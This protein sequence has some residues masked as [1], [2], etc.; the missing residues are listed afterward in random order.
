M[1]STREL[2][3]SFID[4]INDRYSRHPSYVG[5]FYWAV[6]TQLLLGN[7]VSACAFVFV[8]S[9]FFSSRIVGES[10][11]LLF[12]TTSEIPDEEKHLVKF[13]G[14]EYVQYR[15]RVGTCLPFKTSE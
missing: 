10:I 2:S 5:F 7:L 13:F 11:K 15:K 9:R 12:M 8:L 3:L 6:A 1:V 14:D 4:N